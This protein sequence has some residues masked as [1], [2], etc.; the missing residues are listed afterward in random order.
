MSTVFI[1]VLSPV[2]SANVLSF[3][4]NTYNL[5]SNISLTFSASG[6]SINDTCSQTAAK[7]TT[8]LNTFFVQNEINFT[9]TCSYDDQAMQGKFLST[10]SEHV[11]QSWSQ[12]DFEITQNTNTT[13]AIVKIKS[14]PALLTVSEARTLASVT[15]LSYTDADGNNLTDDQVADLICIAS[16]DLC[17]FLKNNIVVT[18]YLQHQITDWQYS[19]FLKKTPV[20]N[21]YAPQSRL[22][23]IFS[24]TTAALYSTAKQN[25]SLDPATGELSYRFAQNYLYMYEPFDWQNEI[26]IVYISGFFTIPDEIK[27]VLGS[28]MAQ[29]VDRYQRDVSSYRGG[30]FAINYSNSSDGFNEYISILRNFFMSD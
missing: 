29:L 2:A 1:S 28:Y 15:G 7:I 4:I 9:G 25:Y 23:L 26:L 21:F 11:S 19:V 13:G 17:S 5:D 3:D 20:R 8:Q 6:L 27:N 10:R 30:S 16:A 12:C 14:R 18:P 22:P 24:I